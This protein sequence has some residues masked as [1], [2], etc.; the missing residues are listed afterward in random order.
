MKRIYLNRSKLEYAK[1]NKQ[2]ED[3]LI[4]F[5]EKIDEYKINTADN[6]T[7]ANISFELY[8]SL[9][10]VDYGLEKKP[11]LIIGTLFGVK[12]FIDPMLQK[13]EIVFKPTLSSEQEKH[14]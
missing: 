4:C 10:R 14:E 9:L 13:D 8:E 6:P 1:R 5:R 12:I 7:E 2:T 3:A 11:K